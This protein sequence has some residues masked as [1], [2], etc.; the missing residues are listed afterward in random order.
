MTNQISTDYKYTIGRKA[1]FTAFGILII[2]AGFVI[3][4][5]MNASLAMYAAFVSGV[6]PLVTQFC[7]HNSK[8]SIAHIKNKLNGG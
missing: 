2:L 4:V 7:F 3:G 8:I 5:K 6:V 1:F